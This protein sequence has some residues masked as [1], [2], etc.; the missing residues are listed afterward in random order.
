M[1]I[2]KPNKNETEKDFHSRCMSAIWDEY[3]EN[4][5]QANAICYSAWD[6]AKKEEKDMIKINSNVVINKNIM[7][8]KGD[9]I[10]LIEAFNVGD[11]VKMTD[12]G[13]M[14]YGNKYENKIFTIKKVISD[15]RRGVFTYELM[16]LPFT[17]SDVDIQK[18]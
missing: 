1:P 11:K 16:G 15:D 10:K 18:I 9:K 13:L 6:R 12:A 5:K 4:P 3:K 8:E 2:P 7:L 17:V 14:M